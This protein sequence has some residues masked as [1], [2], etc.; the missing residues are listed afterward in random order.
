MTQLLPPAPTSQ[1]TRTAVRLTLTDELRSLRFN[2][3]H[4]AQWLVGDVG[5][6]LVRRVELP[7]PAAQLMPIDKL[8]HLIDTTAHQALAGLQSAQN[9][10]AT[11]VLADAPYRTLTF[12]LEPLLAYFSREDARH[13][14]RQFTDVF[15]WLIRHVLEG[16]AGHAVP[17][18]SAFIT[19]QQAVDEAW[20]TVANNDG[21]LLARLQT[22]AT[23]S[24]GGTLSTDDNALLGAAVFLSLL[25]A[26]PLRDPG[27]PPWSD[28]ALPD[29]DARAVMS[30]LLTA[31]LAVAL[32]HDHTGVP[33]EAAA[34]LQL[35]GQL[36]DARLPY[37]EVAL[38]E[39]HPREAIAA[40][41]AFTLRH[42]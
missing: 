12:G 37:V 29:T 31:V 40:E 23:A 34:A 22:D 30:C 24:A 3:L 32:S 18:G 26:R 11:T 5:A 25:S 6:N 15:Y 33:R 19:R 28:R 1:P 10:A 35:A 8:Q 14:S 21:A 38:R 7:A 13:P 2:L 41:M 4:G 27:L 39:P 9:V 16:K 20:W 42:A 17:A 36:V